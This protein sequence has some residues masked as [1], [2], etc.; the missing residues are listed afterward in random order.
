MAFSGQRLLSQISLLLF[1]SFVGGEVIQL[2]ISHT[3]PL[4]EIHP[5]Q[6]RAV[7]LTRLHFPV[8]ESKQKTREYVDY[9]RKLDG[10]ADDFGNVNVGLQANLYEYYANIAIG[11]PPQIFQV[12][13]DTGSSLL[14]VPTKGCHNCSGFDNDKYDIKSTKTGNLLSCSSDMCSKK[15]CSALPG[16]ADKCLFS[17]SYGDKSTIQG[18]FAQDDLSFPPSNVKTKITFGNIL[19]TTKYGGFQDAIVDGIL[20][21]SYG[22]QSGKSCSPNCVTPV[23]SALVDS[24]EIADIFSMR[25]TDLNGNETVGMLTL[26]SAG[27][28]VGNTISGSLVESVYYSPIVEESYYVVGM[29]DF[30]IGQNSIGTHSI[31]KH[32]AIV[33]SGTTFIVLPTEVHNDVKSAFQANFCDLPGICGDNTIF[34][35]NMCLNSD[36]VNT[37]AL[38]D[39]YP[40]ITMIL[41]GVQLTLLPTDYLRPYKVKTDTYYCFGI[42]DGGDLNLIVLGQVFMRPFHIIFDRANT[43]IGFAG[44]AGT[45]AD[46]PLTERGL[47]KLWQICAIG[48]GGT[49]FIGAIVTFVSIACYRRRRAMAFVEDDNSWKQDDYDSHHSINTEDDEEPVNL[50][51]RKTQSAELKV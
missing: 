4:V 20:G 42:V 15:E 41:E 51:L 40:N 7:G 18:V 8:E 48:V 36:V 38:N 10:R 16:F 24:G 5:Q 31:H 25:L 34:N 30:T 27:D 17:I 37:T 28:S 3:Q 6:P 33:D 45:L 9:Y 49:L 43:R 50:S 44:K 1:V 19:T 39:I 32:R 11:S 13:V 22:K 14:A 2:P 46:A 12:Q 23:F 35:L 29:N 26:G 21:L 47:L